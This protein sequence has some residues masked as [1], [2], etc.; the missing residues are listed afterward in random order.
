MLGPGALRLCEKRPTMHRL[1]TYLLWRPSKTASAK[2]IVA[3]IMT[4]S[5]GLL[6]GAGGQFADKSSFSIIGLNVS[7][8]LN[9]KFYDPPHLRLSDCVAPFRCV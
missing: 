5:F 6:T 8:G 4:V 1:L 3:Y 7:C 2:R 9:R